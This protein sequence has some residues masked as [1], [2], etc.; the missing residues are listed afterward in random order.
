MSRK[1]K[2]ADLKLYF[3]SFNIFFISKSVFAAPNADE[4]AK[5]LV[6]LIPQDRAFISYSD[7][8]VA[9]KTERGKQAFAILKNAKIFHGEFGGTIIETTKKAV[10]SGVKSGKLRKILLITQDENEGYEY[11]KL[12]YEDNHINDIDAVG[13]DNNLN[14][15]QYV[16]EAP[17]EDF[18]FKFKVEGVQ[19]KYLKIIFKKTIG[20]DKRTLY[21]ESDPKTNCIAIGPNFAYKTTKNLLYETD[22]FYLVGELNG[23]KVISQ[24]YD[25]YFE[26]T[27]NWFVRVINGQIQCEF[28]SGNKPKPETTTQ[29]VYDQSTDDTSSTE[30]DSLLGFH[31][32]SID[33]IKSSNEVRSDKFFGQKVI[34]TSTSGASYE[35]NVKEND[36]VYYEDG[37]RL[38]LFDRFAGGGQG[39]IYHTDKKGIVAKIM[40]NVDPKFKKRLETMASMKLGEKN[41]NLI[42]PLDSLYVDDGTGK[43]TKFVGYTMREI[44][45]G[46]TIKSYI[47][48]DEKKKANSF[49]IFSYTREELLLLIISWLDSM[50]YL[51][52][53]N[54]VIRDIKSQNLMLI[55]RNKT[56]ML[57]IDCDGFQFDD[58]I[59]TAY[60]QGYLP[61][62]LSE[63]LV[64]TIY[65]TK[66]ADDFT[67]FLVLMEL[68]V[69][70][71][72][73]TY[74]QRN[75]EG[76][77]DYNTGFPYSMNAQETQSK[78]MGYPVINW[79][80]LPKYV[81]EAFISVGSKNGTRTSP[82]NRMTSE[83]WLNLFIDYYRDLKNGKLAADKDANVSCHSITSK[84]IDYKIVD[85]ERVR[86]VQDI[87]KEF[88]IDRAVEAIFKKAKLAT[89]NKIDVLNGLKTTGK[90]AKKGAMA[91]RVNRDIGI[92][93]EVEYAYNK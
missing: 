53:R 39:G 12:D 9:L 22:K 67:V 60:T 16:Y 50:V 55:P 30:S 20:V 48:H 14:G 89:V 15:Y 57:V 17:V 13:F 45:K 72:G 24:P 83:E 33:P 19:L 36:Y 88:S 64:H 38:K 58:N 7:R 11:E 86:K 6:T 87:Q 84:P 42:W 8:Q 73:A 62:E 31:L 29:Q 61:P 78:V 66:A 93:C 46:I 65:Q 41:P 81:K 90:F 26:N 44:E 34:S 32:Y 49:G 21:E 25:F 82:K 23:V 28:F 52:K 74:S 69:T 35:T 63:N 54:I 75:I 68:L 79:S 92:L 80:H 77:A 91:V 76:Q 70:K 59:A 3:N 71:G 2:I 37:R 85:I 4:I 27:Q 56:T 1:Q 43:K 47:S 18:V 40:K 10:E 5:K 51:H